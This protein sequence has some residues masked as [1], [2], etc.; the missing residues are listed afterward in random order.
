MI[1]PRN[2][3][4]DRARSFVTLLVVAH[5]AALAY[6]VYGK[7]Y[8]GHYDWSTAP[9]IDGD[10]WIGLDLFVLFNDSFFMSLM[11]L[12]SGLFFWPTLTR[13]GDGGFLRERGRRLGIPFA[14]VV[15]FVM[16]LAYYPSFRMTGSDI[17]L[18]AFWLRTLTVGPWPAGPAWFVWLLLAFDLLAAAGHRWAPGP[19]ERLGHLGAGA[20][21]RPLRLFAVLLGVAAL[22][23]F[24]MAI[25]F[26]AARWLVFGPFAV[27]ASRPLLYLAWFLCGVVLGAGGLERGLLARDGALRRDWAAWLAAGAAAFLALAALRA[28]PA[29]LDPVAWRIATGAALVV[30]CAA[31]VFATLAVFLR[32]A[33]GPSGPLDAFRASAYG[34]YLVHYVFIVWLQYALLGAALPALLKAVLVFAGTLALSWGAI[35]AAREIPLVARTI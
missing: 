28:A 6:V 21:R 18:G 32:F 23:W 20:R 11:F 3:A 14:L 34:V 15:V 8:P 7:F 22:G 17:G 16:P 31:L 1:A 9:I 29:S 19:L 35:A 26:G 12:L 13:K 25:P 4:L 2:L 27:Q 24:A 33:D 5:H 30:T 10:K